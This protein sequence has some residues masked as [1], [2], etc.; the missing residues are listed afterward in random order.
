MKT[1]RNWR[2]NSKQNPERGAWA[3]A[4]VNRVAEAVRSRRGR[5]AGGVAVAL[6]ALAGGLWLLLGGDEDGNRPPDSRAREYQDVD[7]CLLTGADGIAQGTVA[8][9]VW[10]GMQQASEETRARVSW[11][12]VTGEQSAA[13]VRPFLNGLVQRQCEVV[14]TVGTPQAQA[15]EAIAPQ[16]PSLPFLV[17]GKGVATAKNNVTVVPPGEG[18]KAAVEREI[19]DAASDKRS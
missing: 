14:L 10:D 16:H 17:V 8:S 2:S 4:L 3:P 12:P 11:V 7:A 19:R 9:S 6:L 18:L 5:L 13:N 15:V 1:R